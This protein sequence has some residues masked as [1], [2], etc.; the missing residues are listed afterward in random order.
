MC[1]NCNVKHYLTDLCI[2]RLKSAIGLLFRSVRS[3]RKFLIIRPFENRVG[4][5]VPAPPLTTTV[6][7]RSGT[8]QRV[9]DNKLEKRNDAV[10]SGHQF[11]RNDTSAASRS[12]VRSRTGGKEGTAVGATVMIRVRL[13]LRSPSP[14]VYQVPLRITSIKTLGAPR[15]SRRSRTTRPPPGVLAAS[16]LLSADVTGRR[17]GRVR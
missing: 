13:R 17:E 10:V 7:P 3:D 16:L 8:P 14:V 4:G 11:F 1:I 12:D 9:R 6:S 2:W 15:W 5:G